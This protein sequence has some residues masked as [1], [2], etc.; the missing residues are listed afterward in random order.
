[1]WYGF[2]V[3]L[4]RT[5]KDRLADVMEE[6]VLCPVCKLQASEIRFDR[7]PA[8]GQRKFKIRECPSCGIGWTSPPV[9]PDEIGNWYPSEY[10]GE[11]NR[12][13]L[14]VF[15]AITRW[16]RHRRA[17]AI[18]GRSRPG[19]VLDVG[20]GR[21]LLLHELRLLGYQP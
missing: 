1:M 4:L 21:G 9:A 18:A 17:L 7:V 15:E 19:P 6:E 20:C 10:Y 2:D 12:R 16:F 13:F 11:S 14:P 3:P 5:R 8:E